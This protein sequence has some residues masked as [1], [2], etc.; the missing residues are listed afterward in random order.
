MPTNTIDVDDYMSSL[1]Q[2]KMDFEKKWLEPIGDHEA[3]LMLILSYPTVDMLEEDSFLAG[4]S[5]LELS[6]ALDLV[7]L[8]EGDYYLTAMVKCGIGTASKPGTVLIE[9]WAAMLDYEI[10]VVKPRLILTLGS[11]PFKRIKKEQAK[12]TEYMGN[13]VDS[14]YGKLLPN[15]S[16]GMIVTQ[17]PRKRPQFR[18]VFDLA[19]R[20]IKGTLAYTDYDWVVID[21]PAI[22]RLVIQQYID[23]KKFIIG[24]D[25]EWYGKKMTDDEVMYT[26][27]YSCE[28]HKAIVLDISKDGI[29]ENRELLL[30]MKPLLEHPK[31]ERM[32]W[33][34]RV[35]DER[36]IL[37]GIT[38]LEE[39]LAFDGMKA[40][41]FIDSR[42]PKGL[43]TGIRHF[44]NYRPYYKDL[45]EI[46]K[47]N[48]LESDELAKT[49]FLAPDVFWS[50]CAGDAVAHRT[51]CIAMRELIMA[52]PDSQ[53]DYWF[54]I[55]LPLT[56]YFIDLEM[57]GIP[58][59]MEVMEQMAQQYVQKYDELKVELLEQ[60]KT[61]MES[62]NPNSTPDKRMLLF[63]FLKLTPAYYT[64]AGKSPKPRVWY[65]KQKPQTRKLYSP[66]TNGKS[67]STIAFDLESE[68]IVDI[69]NEE[70]KRKHKL[71]KN[72]LD[73]TR[74][75]V[76]ANKFLSKQGTSFDEHADEEEEL[77][78]KKTSYFA[79]VCK[80]GRIHP[81]FYECLNNFRSS[82]RPNVQNPASKVLS[83]IPEIFVP[84]YKSMSE[85][86]QDS[87]NDKIPRN[88]RHIFC[89][90]DPDFYWA[91]CDIA[92]ADLMLAAY[93]SKDQLYIN[94]LLAGNFHLKKAREYFQD[95]KIS[96]SDYS[97]Y[98]AAKS[99]TFRVAYTAELLSAA[100]P[101]QAEIY[102]ES[103]IHIATERI[104]F[105]LKS[106]EKYKAYMRYRT[107]CIEQV[108]EHQYIENARGIKYHFEDS[109][110]FKILSGWY[111]ESLAYPI[112]SELAFFMYDIV[113]SMK[114]QLQ[115]DNVWK[116]Y[117]FPVN[118]VHDASYN[119]VHK[120][121]LKDNY[122][123][124][125]C[126][127]FFTDK[128]RCITGDSLGMEM[129]VS[130]RWKGD[131]EVFHGET[132]WN[133]S[134]K[135]WDWKK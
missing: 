131:H 115:K 114:K 94:D 84:G 128:C 63:E 39:T 32:G 93:L 96:K 35:D 74:V 65:E 70:L 80:D 34:I 40:C 29:N 119:L 117:I 90:G 49:K 130:E 21:D 88:L 104:E 22:N 16:P 135:K 19:N 85:V 133:F 91:E 78:A 8:K 51:A 75:G 124:E 126:K 129:S 107:A 121:M 43:E 4:P 15:Y 86:E 66:S 106:W 57:T 113:V 17:D 3:P 53:R 61:Y 73:L 82:S 100:I 92:G 67:L 52:L 122:F 50:Y 33:N 83:H 5:G 30:T 69:H 98:V 132:T 6:N 13:I 11:E 112:A 101:I 134:T 95:P 79:A 105:A 55:Y 12:L 109:E 81:S 108:K 28:P 58:I 23:E 72:M 25:A 18:E 24:Y 20:Y 7:G 54:N 36:L 27:Q 26:F 38:P 59:D 37:R 71:V 125:I 123:Q 31:A 41:G 110:D 89:A 10:S 2:M 62:F 1:K 99:I 14:P 127:S 56:N 68:I 45:T 77:E 47:A 48:K 64:K 116:R 76:F 9:E 87:N 60:T 118:S 42:Q 44:T 97:K 102:A 103:G 120:D 111:N 46:L